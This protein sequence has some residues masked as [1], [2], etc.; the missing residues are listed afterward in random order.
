MQLTAVGLN[1]QT[2]PLSIRE[3]LAFAAAC[4]PEA[5]RNLAR[6]KAATEAVILSTCN[7]TELYCVG[8]SEEIIRWLADYHSLPIEEISPYLYT[9]G[10]QETV[11]HAFRVAC[12]LDSM[13]LGEPQIL[14]QIKDAVRV[15]QEQESMGKKLNALFQKTFSVAKEVRT[16][17]AVGENSVSMASASVKLAEQIFP[18]IGDL[19]VLFIGA[20]EMIELVATYFA[21]KSPR[22]MTV[23]NRTL[24][25]AQELCDKL[26]VN[27]EPCLLSDLPAILHD[28]DVVVSSTASQLPIVG[29]GMVER[30]LKQRQSMPLFMLDLAV[31]RDIEAEVGDLNDAYLYTVD[32]M[33]NIVQSGKEARQKAAAAAETLVSEKVAEFVRQQQGRQSVPL[34]KALRDEGE[35]ARKQVL[36]N[37]MKQ[38]AKGATAE[39]V[40]ERLSVQLTN[41]LLHSPTQTLN[42]AGEEDKDLVHAVAQIYHLDK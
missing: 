37:A 31:P 8:D 7:R 3:K 10:M 9:L 14:G 42:K 30:A 29:K 23:A 28:Y 35:K 13:V 5:V 33:V 2:A 21:A 39:E 20:G 18:D 36:E 32:D 1:H 12:G 6:S 41:K 34:I 26:G 15:A 40:L 16:D 19:N 25:R 38:L 24:A 11:R 17:T 22:L 27:A 4:L